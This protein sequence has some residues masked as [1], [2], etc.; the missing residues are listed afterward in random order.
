MN[1]RIIITETDDGVEVEEFCQGDCDNE[2]IKDLSQNI[3]GNHRL[4][5]KAM[6]EMMN[7]CR[8]IKL[9]KED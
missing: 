2:W 7:K 6:R 9:N 1:R 3:S 8:K 4:L 5:H